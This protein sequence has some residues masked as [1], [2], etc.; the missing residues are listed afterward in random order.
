MTD[1]RIFDGGFKKALILENPSKVLD[2]RLTA[3]GIVADRLPESATLDRDAV[4]ARLKSE[5]HDLIFK[6]SRF[7]I[8]DEVLR[9]SPNLAAIMLCCIGD[10]SVDK[11]ACAR[12]GVLVMNE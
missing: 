2:E 1:V 11:E 5:Q 8:D 3:Q 4:I 6:R 7:E 9:A 10:D 12:H